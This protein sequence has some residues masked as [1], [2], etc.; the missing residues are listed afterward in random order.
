MGRSL[1]PVGWVVVLEVE[2]LCRGG[3]Q[4]PLGKQDSKKI[5]CILTNKKAGFC[6]QKGMN[7][8][9]NAQSGM[10]FMH[11]AKRKMEL[12]NVAVGRSWKHRH[13]RCWMWYTKTVHKGD[14]IPGDWEVLDRIPCPVALAVD[15]LCCPCTHRQMSVVT[16]LVNTWVSCATP[17]QDRTL[18]A[19]WILQGAIH[20]AC[21]LEMF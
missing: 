6:F 13:Y 10:G 3:R 12:H 8:W 16:E 15:P 14:L 17:A 18:A 9:S 5:N 20:T 7:S 4:E 11:S 1:P 19:W 21:P 2:V